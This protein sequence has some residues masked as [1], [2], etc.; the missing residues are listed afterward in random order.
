MEALKNKMRIPFSSPGLGQPC[1]NTP[2]RSWNGPSRATVT[3]VFWCM[4]QVLNLSYIYL[5]ACLFIFNYYY[6]CQG[7]FPLK[8]TENLFEPCDKC[9]FHVILVYPICLICLCLGCFDLQSSVPSLCSACFLAVE[10]L[11]TEKELAPASS[12]C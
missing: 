9:L 3:T 5:F 1:M 12:G 10:K 8:L 2:T 6:F 11:G 4:A 7:I